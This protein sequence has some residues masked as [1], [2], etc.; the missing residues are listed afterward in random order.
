MLEKLPPVAEQE[1]VGQLKNV[2]RYRRHA[3]KLQQK[4]DRS[5]ESFIRVNATEW[6]IDMP[7]RERDAI[8]KE[9][10]KIVEAARAG[11]YENPNIVKLVLNS[12]LARSHADAM[13]D[14]AEKEMEAV[15]KRLRVFDWVSKQKGAGALGLAT[16]IAETGDLAGYSAPCKVWKRLG[17]APYQGLAGSSWKR[18]SWRP[19]ALTKEEWIANPFSGQR[20]ALIH[21][22]ATWLVNTQV[23]GAEK[24]GTDY[25]EAKGPYGK[26][27]VARRQKTAAE[28]ADWS[29]G[30]A[31]NDALRITMKAFLKDLWNEW[32]NRSA[33]QACD[34]LQTTAVGGGA[35]DQ[36]KGD[37]QSKAVRRATSSKKSADQDH[38]DLQSTVVGGGAAD[39]KIDELQ[40]RVVRRATSSKR[41]TKAK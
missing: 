27:Y 39:Q 41:T 3:M 24:S 4:I 37:L 18:E 7:E 30:H 5:T 23:T 9:V 25:G 14:E 22:I 26:I 13:R 36:A 34:E 28:H 11:T 35:A 8:N 31:R 19:R 10:K 2:H 20:Y 40:T 16:I 38:G 15:A 21:Q 32:N 6:S 17:F 29:K 33:D 1:V 12:D